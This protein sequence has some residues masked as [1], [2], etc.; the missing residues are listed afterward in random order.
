MDQLGWLQISQHQLQKDVTHRLAFVLVDRR[1]NKCYFT[2]LIN[3]LLL[4]SYLSHSAL[5][6]RQLNKS[7]IRT[8]LSVAKTGNASALCG[9]WP[10]AFLH[11]LGTNCPEVVRS[12]THISL[13]RHKTALLG[14]TLL[15]GVRWPGGTGSQPV[16]A[17]LWPWGGN[18]PLAA[19]VW[20]AR[21]PVGE[22]T[23]YPPLGSP[24]KL[25]AAAIQLSSGST[26][27]IYLSLIHI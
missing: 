9:R 13:A 21:P 15:L 18:A 24:A 22:V 7:S 27:L 5:L 16:H 12:A 19:L 20:I 14:A 8:P 3:V 10:F 23:A 11:L 25:G 6:F 26:S 2:Y 1:D 17:G 4:V